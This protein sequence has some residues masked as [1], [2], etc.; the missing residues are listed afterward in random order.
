MVDPLVFGWWENKLSDM[1]LMLTG[2][3]ELW[4]EGSHLALIL[5]TTVWSDWKV[6]F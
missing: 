6:I 1:L 5:I 2:L 3:G 4:K